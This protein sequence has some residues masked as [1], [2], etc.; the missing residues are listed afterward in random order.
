MRSNTEPW[1]FRKYWSL[2]EDDVF[3]EFRCS[4]PRYNP[5]YPGLNIDYTYTPADYDA[6]ITGFWGSRYRFGASFEPQ[7]I[8]HT[9][10]P[11]PPAIR[12]RPWASP[13]AAGR[14]V[15]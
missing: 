3:Y 8:P 9:P 6:D 2:V 12:S 7:P 15:R 4:N 13:W 14:A 5:V 11:R 1:I 10:E